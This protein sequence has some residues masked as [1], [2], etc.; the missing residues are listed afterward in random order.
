MKLVELFDVS[1]A[2]SFIFDF[3]YGGRPWDQEDKAI[4]LEKS[5]KELIRSKLK[6]L[7]RI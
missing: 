7:L 2:I 6:R 4:K 1:D 5:F 3:Y